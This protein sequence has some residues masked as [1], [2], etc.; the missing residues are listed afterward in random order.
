MDQ[1]ITL[2]IAGREYP[3]KASSPEMEQL[4]RLAAE[5]I[6]SKLAVYDSRFPG[7]DLV[8]KFAFVCLNEAVAR[9]STQR[10]YALKEEQERQLLEQTKAYL[11]SIEKESSR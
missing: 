8:D 10:K 4:M 7:K 1:S 2:K 9:L 5:S 11:E 3:L 6:N